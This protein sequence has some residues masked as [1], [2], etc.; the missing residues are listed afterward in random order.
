[1]PSQTL[2]FRAR[3]QQKSQGVCSV[4]PKTFDSPDKKEIVGLPSLFEVGLLAELTDED[5]L[6]DSEK[7]WVVFITKTDGQRPWFFQSI[8]ISTVLHLKCIEN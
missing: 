1:M 8:K 6:T 4:L 7:F 2:A 5:K 3:Q